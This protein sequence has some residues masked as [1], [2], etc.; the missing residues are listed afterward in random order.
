[1][2]KKTE[3]EKLGERIDLSVALTERDTARHELR[4][5]QEDIAIL[6]RTNAEL[7]AENE[8]LR[9]LLAELERRIRVLQQNEAKG[10]P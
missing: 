7:R 2:K 10:A 3:V 6:K 9:G 8:R 5:A 4:V 1:V